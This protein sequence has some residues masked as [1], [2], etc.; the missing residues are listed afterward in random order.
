MKLLT[1]KEFNQPTV[2]TIETLQTLS[3]LELAQIL[4]L[5]SMLK[6]MLTCSPIYNLRNLQDLRKRKN[7]KK[8]TQEIQ[9]PIQIMVQE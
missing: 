9:S 8:I 5:H 3:Y 1:I 6:I 4:F 2:S 7:L